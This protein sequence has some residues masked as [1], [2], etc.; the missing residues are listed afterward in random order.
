[1]GA[2]PSFYGELVRILVPIDVGDEIIYQGKHSWTTITQPLQLE[3]GV[4]GFFVGRVYRPPYGFVNRI[5]VNT[6]KWNGWCY[7]TDEE[8]ESVTQ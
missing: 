7:L 2:T 6:D 1:M 3:P 5:K 8:I 4:T